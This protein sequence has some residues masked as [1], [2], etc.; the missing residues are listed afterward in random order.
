M[1]GVRK[2]ELNTNFGPC[3]LTLPSMQPLPSQTSQSLRCRFLGCIDALSAKPY[4]I[5]W[6]RT[7]TQPK[8]T[9]PVCRRA[10]AFN[11]CESQ[12]PRGILIGCVADFDAPIVPSAACA[13][14]TGCWLG[15]APR[16]ATLDVSG[17]PLS[18][19]YAT[20]RSDCYNLVSG[21][22]LA[23]HVSSAP[24]TPPHSFPPP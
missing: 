7:T 12:I 11:I 9:L 19:A 23:P 3:A 18:D 15:F 24:L 14:C 6:G 2:R 4:R 5:A 16:P 22:R 17:I 20:N 10:R 13:E 1:G 21:Q 8:K